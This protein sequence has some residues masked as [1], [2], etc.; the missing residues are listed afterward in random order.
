MHPTMYDDPTGK[1][2]SRC[3]QRLITA[4]EMQPSN[5][6]SRKPPS[7]QDW[8]ESSS[9]GSRSDRHEEHSFYGYNAKRKRTPLGRQFQAQ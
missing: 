7:P 9:S 4:K 2:T 5:I 6:S 3:S 1:S 8:S